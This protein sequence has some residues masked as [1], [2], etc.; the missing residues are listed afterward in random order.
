VLLPA[1][2]IVQGC[3]RR[4]V[5]LPF[6]AT[7][8]CQASPAHVILNIRREWVASVALAL[9]TA[10][11]AAAPAPRAELCELKAAP[12]PSYTPLTSAGAA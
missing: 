4:M 2:D 5:T 11:S 9:P 6:L 1:A 10:S 3:K 8:A 7:Q 12:A